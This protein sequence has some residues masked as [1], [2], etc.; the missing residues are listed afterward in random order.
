MSFQLN[1]VLRVCTH[2]L[3]PQITLDLLFDSLPTLNVK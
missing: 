2:Y 3:Y 1:E